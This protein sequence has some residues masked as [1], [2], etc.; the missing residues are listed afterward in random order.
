M[1]KWERWIAETCRVNSERA[2]LLARRVEKAPISPFLVV[3]WAFAVAF[4]VG[5]WGLLLWVLW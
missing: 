3:A 4:C 5:V 2:D 1:A